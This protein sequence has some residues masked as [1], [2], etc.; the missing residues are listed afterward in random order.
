MGRCGQQPCRGARSGEPSSSSSQELARGGREKGQ[1][2]Q[3]LTG[4][5]R[6]RVAACWRCSGAG[7]ATSPSPAAAPLD[8]VPSA[9]TLGRT[10][11]AAA[12]GGPGKEVW[13]RTSTRR[14][15]KWNQEGQHGTPKLGAIF[16]ATCRWPQT[17]VERL[18]RREAVG[19]SP[20]HFCEVG[21][22]SG[23]V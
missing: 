21:E 11:I 20:Q 18:L 22:R 23:E 12:T 2:G 3:G 13:V 15:T 19:S 4:G 1:G 5:R 10:A 6:Q 17:E 14:G 8:G 9:A 16:H 7:S